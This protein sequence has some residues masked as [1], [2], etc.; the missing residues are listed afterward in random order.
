MKI[1]AHLQRSVRQ[2]RSKNERADHA[3]VPEVINFDFEL[4]MTLQKYAWV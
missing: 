2:T 1:G 4:T 3:L